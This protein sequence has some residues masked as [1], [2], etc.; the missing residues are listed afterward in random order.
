MRGRR[1]GGHALRTPCRL[2]PANAGTT[3]P[4]GAPLPHHQ[5]HPRECGDDSFSRTPGLATRGSP[6]RMR[7]R[8]HHPRSAGFARRLTPANA[9][10]TRSRCGDICRPAAHPRE[11]GDDR[12]PAPCWTSGS[13]S[14]PRMRG[15][16][17]SIV[18]VLWAVRLTP[19]NAGTTAARAVAAILRS[20][21]P[22]ECGDD[23]SSIFFLAASSGSPPRMRGRLWLLSGGRR[24]SRLT[25]ANAGTTYGA[26]LALSA[27]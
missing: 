13:G 11:C 22:R 23:I 5:A 21:H 15:R 24:S 10:T 18:A 26:Y 27:P 17:G 1:G 25:P 14:P 3:V 12:L 8:R 4:A 20:A 19:A 7:G 16:P 2:T 9:G 6:P